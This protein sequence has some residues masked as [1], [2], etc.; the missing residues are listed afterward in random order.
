MWSSFLSWLKPP[1]LYLIIND[2]TI[3][4]VASSRF[5]HN[6]GDD[7]SLVKTKSNFV[8]GAVSAGS[9]PDLEYEMKMSFDYGGDA[10]F[11]EE[12]QR[13]E[14]EET[15]DDD[16]GESTELLVIKV[17]GLPVEVRQAATKIS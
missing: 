12:K 5:Y 4:I 6:D 2:I 9:M 11:N 14:E 1:Y 17:R 3:T 16:G 8:G 13:V 10:I 15:D 7:E